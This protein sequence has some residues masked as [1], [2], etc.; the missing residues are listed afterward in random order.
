M[1]VYNEGE[2]IEQE[3]RTTHKVILLRI[4]GSELIVAEDGSTDGTKK[5]ISNLVDELGIIHS[6]S[7]KR[8]GY[9]KALKDAFIM[10]KCPYIFFTDT[11]NK[12]NTEDFWKL[13][14]SRKDNGLV[15][16]IK[17]NRTDQWYRK[18]LTW[19]YNLI[20]SYY[21]KIK[22]TDADAGF[23]LYKL[24]AA[25][26]VFHENWINRDLIN[27]E[28]TLRIKYSGYSIKEVP[29]F[30]RQRKGESRGLPLKK[31][32]G[33]TYRVLR[34]FRQLRRTLSDPGYNKEVTKGD[35]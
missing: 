16:G 35:E 30:Y 22:L 5:I 19:A 24:E 33:A 13:Y 17:T 28:I 6:T 32:P 1:N 12:H 2:T 15:V 8:K 7:K 23:R 9:A 21:F 10:A 3:I 18:F 31:M 20:L 29:I 4:P 27:S 14:S 34:N 26:K 25:Q 11:G